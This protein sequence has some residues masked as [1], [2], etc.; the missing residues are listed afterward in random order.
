MNTSPL[1]MEC[2][3]VL[4]FP[5]QFEFSFPFSWFPSYSSRITP[6]TYPNSILFPFFAIS[7]EDGNLLLCAYLY[8]REN[9]W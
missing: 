4:S 1:I 5:G 7:L 6:S 3:L 9:G 2:S 8:E